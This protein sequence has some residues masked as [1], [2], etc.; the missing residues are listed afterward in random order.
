MVYLRLAIVFVRLQL[1]ETFAM[2]LAATSMIDVA[3]PPIPGFSRELLAACHT[4]I[5]L[6]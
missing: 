4:R 6:H 2:S 1:Q 3:R 5:A